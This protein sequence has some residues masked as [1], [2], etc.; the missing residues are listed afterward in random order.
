[1]LSSLLVQNRCYS[2]FLWDRTESWDCGSTPTPSSSFGSFFFLLLI[3][4]SLPHPFTFSFSPPSHPFQPRWWTGGS[5]P[6]HWPVYATARGVLCLKEVGSW[7]LNVLSALTS[8]P[9]KAA[10]KHTRGSIIC[11]PLTQN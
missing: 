10:L 5:C 8:V 7:R 6:R 11:M 1:M 4:P 3:F 9:V 2:C